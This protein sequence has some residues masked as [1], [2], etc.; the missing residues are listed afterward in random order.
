M[1][2]LLDC[3]VKILFSWEKQRGSFYV[4]MNMELRFLLP[5]QMD[6]GERAAS[7]LVRRIQELEAQLAKAENT[8]AYLRMELKRADDGGAIV[9]QEKY[10]AE[11]RCCSPLKKMGAVALMG[12]AT[13]QN[14]GIVG[15]AEIAPIIL[16]SEKAESHG[17]GCTQRIRARERKLVVG[18]AMPRLEHGED[19]GAAEEEVPPIYGSPEAG[20]GS[21]S[22]AEGEDPLVSPVGSGSDG[23]SRQPERED[24]GSTRGRKL[25]ASSALTRCPR[26]NEVPP[27][28]EPESKL[29]PESCA[30]A[31]TV[32]GARPFWE[33]S[34][35]LVAG[36]A[37]EEGSRA[38]LAEAENA[39]ASDDRGVDED[40]PS[41]GKDG[42]PHPQLLQGAGNRTL[43]YTFRRKRKRGSPAGAEPDSPPERDGVSPEPA[44]KTA[45]ASRGFSRDSRRIVQVARQ[46]SPPSPPPP[47]QL[48]CQVER[49]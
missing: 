30:E 28:M 32:A 15:G 12:E 17:N 43:K 18:G 11:D 34:S 6:D 31:E 21:L 5:L 23:G 24:G 41:V 42:A 44:Q 13:A 47:L 3:P 19:N 2:N 7:G 40:G 26:S 38:S 20:D 39:D 29:S 33:K 9:A 4:C 36:A 10:G 35:E 14:P 16:G 48:T 49:R 46:V 8:I 1:L 27:N 25:G 37:F 22:R 45:F